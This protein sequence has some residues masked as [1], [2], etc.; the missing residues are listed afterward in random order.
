MIESRASAAPTTD[1]A[2]PSAEQFLF[3][4]GTLKA[5]FANHH[6]LAQARYIAPACTEHEFALY[7][8]D[9]PFLAKS[10]A[11]YRVQ[12]ELYALDAATLAQVDQLEEHPSDYCREL[13][14]IIT[15]TG[16]RIWA[17]VYFHPA[18]QGRLLPRGDYQADLG[19]LSGRQ[20]E[21]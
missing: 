21:A 8:L 19:T 5:G 1:S 12:G 13:S 17:W 15:A 6:Y 9:Y 4:Y 16:E 11:L 7:T 2:T 18:P 3:V 14:P 20:R 10:P